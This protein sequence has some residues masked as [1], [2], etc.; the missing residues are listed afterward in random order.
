[1]TEEFA[2][3]ELVKRYKYLYKNA[4]FILAPFM[5][6]QTN[7][8]YLISKRKFKKEFNKELY[9]PIISLKFDF[10]NPLVPVLEEFLLSDITIENSTLY[11]K[12]EREKNNKDYLEKVKK[13]LELVDK[14][15]KDKDFEPLMLKL[16]LYKIFGTVVSYLEEQSGDLKNKNNKLLV[17]DEYYRILRYQ[18]NGK[19]YVSGRNLSIYDCDSLIIPLNKHIPSREKTDIGVT[20]NSFITRIINIPRYEDNWGVF[21]ENEKQTIYLEF[22][23]E[24]PWDLEIN[25]NQ[26]KMIIPTSLP[27]IENTTPCGESFLIKEKEI[28][29]NPIDP[30]Y[31]YY[32]L[33]P[34]C[35]YIV[36]IPKEI[37]SDKI[38]EIIEKRCQED[39]NLFKKMYLYSQLC[40]LDRL[41]TNN[42][43]KLIII[44]K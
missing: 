2:K 16:D 4:H 37:L 8:E 41:P 18:N 27:D 32:Q 12:L 13:G 38:K 3:Q 6:E 23:D 40:Y 28:F 29:I 44:K 15:N 33:C 26:N 39:S 25:C 35:G 30:I 14:N 11:Q 36:N 17:L 5:H 19:T 1:M 34:H 10:N 24:L 7:E 43:K 20:K 22:H 9:S 42:Q 31:R 21:T